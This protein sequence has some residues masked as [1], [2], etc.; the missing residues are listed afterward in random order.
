MLTPF[1]ATACL[2]LSTAASLLSGAG[3]S[4]T[5]PAWKLQST[6]KIGNDVVQLSSSNL[7]TSSWYSVG[8]RGTLMASLMQ[9]EVYTESDLFYST[10]L[11]KVDYSQFYMPWIYFS[12]FDVESTNG[13]HFFLKTNGISSRAD[14]YLNG[15]LV[16]DKNVQAGAYVGLTYDITSH[17]KEDGNV[18]LVRVYPTDYQRDLALG[19]VD[20]NPYPPDNGTGIWRDVEIKQTGPVSISLPQVIAKLDGNLIIKL[21][22]QNLQ[23]NGVHGEVMCVVSDPQG[24]ELE[25]PRFGFELHSKARQT[26]SL[27][28]TVS[29]PQIWWPRQWGDQPLY[30]TQCTASTSAGISDL[31]SITRF[32]IRTLTSKLNL[33]ND[34]MFYINEKP[35]QVIGAGYT[36]DIFLRFSPEK[37][38]TQ[39]TQVLDMGLN[40]IRLE[41]KQEHP[42]LYSLADELGLMIMAGW[43]CCDKWEG[44]SYNDEGSGQKW[45][46]ADYQIANNSMRHEAEMMQSHPS[47]LAFLIGSDFWPDDKAT[48]I[49]VDALK[50]YNW[51][52]PIISSASQRGYPDLLGNGGMKMEGP[53]DWVPPNYWY[54]PETRLGSAFGFASELGAGVGT[55]ELSSLKKFLSKADLED[56]WKHPNKG[57]YHM[58]TNVSSFYT[59]EIYNTAL[60]KRYGAPTSIASARPDAPLEN[61]LLKAQM[62]DYEA[63]RAQ[64]ESYASRW[65][66][67]RPA[68]G[69]I[70]W[71]LNNAWP[72]LHWN[73]FDYY[74]HTGGSFF[75]TKVGSRKE[76]V[77][78]DYET[79]QIYL[80]NRGLESGKRS[81]EIELLGLDGKSMSK[82]TVNAPS[83]PNSSKAIGKVGG[84]DKIKDVALLRLILREGDNV[85]SR[86][87]YWLS[88]KLDVLDWDSSSWYHT[89]VTS[90]ANYTALFSEALPKANVKI[91]PGNGNILLEN[92]LKVPAVFIRLNLI[93][94]TTGE[95][96][97]P[98]FWSDNYI[99]L[100]PGEKMRVRLDFKNSSNYG[101]A[102]IEVSG[103]NVADQSVMIR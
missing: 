12:D 79:G 59:R 28:I 27:N 30:S 31:T 24:K 85:L 40:T 37:L 69:L 33:Y 51:E 5:I 10:A 76:H 46:A 39:F 66:A 97:L 62:M 74:G 6:T 90:Y 89:P 49:Y 63:T 18:L 71:M 4:A 57:L 25:K 45:S 61:Y 32:G 1:L 88:Q 83:N 19:F 60:W 86:N 103:V 56:L 9:N 41:G 14:V 58:S 65:N 36:S 55:P 82:S 100:F 48:K 67:N 34:T 29:N 17:I 64:F 78:Y 75:G 95:D 77:A 3:S 54:D 16:V 52:A 72:S 53:Y 7:S 26:V 87:V 81:L 44:W 11:Q 50:A 92:M 22:V 70:Y 93:D 21:D 13:S 15:N 96:I 98:A 101:G 8:S 47:M 2:V 23:E 84:T 20:W 91:T 99:T 43:E 42:Y 73:L 80:I 68:T 38:R 94:G 35:F 102:R